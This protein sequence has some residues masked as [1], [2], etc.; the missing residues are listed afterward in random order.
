[1]N[2]GISQQTLLGMIEALRLSGTRCTHTDTLQLG[3]LAAIFLLRHLRGDSNE[4]IVLQQ[5]DSLPNQRSL[6]GH[7]GIRMIGVSVGYLALRPSAYIRLSLFAPSVVADLSLPQAGR[8]LEP[9]E[10]QLSGLEMAKEAAKLITTNFGSE[11]MAAVQ[12]VL[13]PDEERVHMDYI[14]LVLGNK[15]SAWLGFQW[16]RR[17]RLGSK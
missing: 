9:Y 16:A 2:S 10:P 14:R 13:A 17:L 12:S 7:A 5:F 1:M 15:I 6:G 8:G 3:V 4:E 11:A